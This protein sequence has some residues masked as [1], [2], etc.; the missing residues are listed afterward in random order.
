M[1]TLNLRAEATDQ[2]G[3]T[4]ATPDDLL[5]KAKDHEADALVAASCASRG[6]FKKWQVD[7][8]EAIEDKLI[9]PAGPA[10]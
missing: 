1:P 8:Y 3:K 5:K 9:F 4:I 10:V 6:F 7:I 2:H